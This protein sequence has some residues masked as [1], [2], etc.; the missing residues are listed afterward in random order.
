MN[1]TVIDAFISYTFLVIII[2]FSLI[3]FS[4]IFFGH[5]DGG[6]V[7]CVD[8]NGNNIIGVECEQEPITLN[9]YIIIMCVCGDSYLGTNL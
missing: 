4:F 2:I 1:Y 8:G 5:N 3:I 9:S 6:V 7:D